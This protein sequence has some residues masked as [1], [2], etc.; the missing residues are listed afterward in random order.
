MPKRR[1][2]ARRARSKAPDRRRPS[3]PPVRRA[4]PR[5]ALLDSATD[6][7]P[8]EEPY[9]AARAAASHAFAGERRGRR[10]AW[11]S[12]LA[13]AADRPAGARDLPDPRRSFP[14]PAGTTAG[15]VAAA[16]RCPGAAPGPRRARARARP[17]GGAAGA[18]AS[19][20]ASAQRTRAARPR[21][22]GADAPGARSLQVR[23]AARARSRAAR[24]RGLA[25]APAARPDRDARGLVAAHAVVGLPV[26]QGVA[27]QARPRSP[28]ASIAAR[29]WRWRSV[30]DPIVLFSDSGTNARNL[31][32]R[33]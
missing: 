33:V 27:P 16:V 32:Q 1:C 21:A 19:G 14:V 13:Q 6:P 30:I 20:R 2:G 7:V 17:P 3:A 29:R 18:A 9:L 12:D 4:P 31:R 24:L 5:G 22:A 10:R 26:T 8:L 25:G 28:S 11:R 23:A 15:A